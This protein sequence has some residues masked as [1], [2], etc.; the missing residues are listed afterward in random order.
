MSTSGFEI[1]SLAAR[2]DGRPLLLIGGSGMLGRAFRAAL[3]QLGASLFAPVHQELDISDPDSIGAVFKSRPAIV[4]NCAA[5]TNVDGAESDPPGADR[6]NNL[7]ARN[8]AAAC[9]KADATLVHFSTDYVFSGRSSSPYR[10]DQPLQPVNVYGRTK[11]DGERAIRE[12][13]PEHLIVRTSW[14]YAPW[15]TNFVRTIARAAKQRPSLRVVNDQRGRPTSSEGLVRTTLALL[16]RGARGTFHGTDGGECTWFEFARSI[17][18]LTG[19]PSS[20]EPCSSEEYPRPAR[21]PAYSVLDVSQTEALIGPLTPWE[22]ALE[23]VIPRL[24]P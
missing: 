4:I 8:L 18:R 7:G 12:E 20:V 24:E 15:G 5:W 22:R 3:E 16:N 14:L 2:L 23:G 17:V 10:P 6:V 9:R 11:A 21:R 1:H 19:A 13:T